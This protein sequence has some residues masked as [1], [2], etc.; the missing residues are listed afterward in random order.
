[1]AFIYSRKMHEDPVPI[2]LQTSIKV[3]IPIYLSLLENPVLYSILRKLM[4]GKNHLCRTNWLF[5]THERQEWKIEV[6]VPR[7][8]EVQSRALCPQVGQWFLQ[9]WMFYFKLRNKTLL[10][11]MP[12]PNRKN[13]IYRDLVITSDTRNH[14][15]EYCRTDRLIW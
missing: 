2:K 9:T 12:P 5:I 11:N 13:T 7:F 4:F 14:I 10:W 8:K 15:S 1:M 3:F 6:T